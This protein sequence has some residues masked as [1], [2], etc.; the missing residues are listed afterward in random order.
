[1]KKFVFLLIA[2]L[3]LTATVCV[4]EAGEEGPAEW[5]VMFYMFGSD[6]ES[7]YEFASLNLT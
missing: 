5:T 1:M 4:A 7:K 6:L 2:M 3:C